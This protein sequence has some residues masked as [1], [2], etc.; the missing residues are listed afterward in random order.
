[1]T[2]DGKAPAGRAPA[3]SGP[4]GRAPVGWAPARSGPDGRAPAGRVPPPGVHGGDGARLA[5]DI[6][7][8]LVAVTGKHASADGDAPRS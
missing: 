2:P 6:I 7:A 3:R 4:D 1:M 5:D 8:A